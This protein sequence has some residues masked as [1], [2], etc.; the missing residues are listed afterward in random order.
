MRWDS[1]P[2]QVANE[3]S[4]R[5]HGRAHPGSARQGGGTGGRTGGSCPGGTGRPEPISIRRGDPHGHGQPQPA[6]HASQ[7]EHSGS[8]VDTMEGEPGIASSGR[9]NLQP[10][11]HEQSRR[12]AGSGDGERG[13]ALEREHG[14]VLAIQSGRAGCGRGRRARQSGPSEPESGSRAWDEREGAGRGT[15]G[16]PTQPT[17]QFGPPAFG[18]RQRGELSSE[19]SRSVGSE[20]KPDELSRSGRVTGRSSRRAAAGSVSRLGGSDCEQ[21]AGMRRGR[22]V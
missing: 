10:D 12:R 9:G 11:A 2:A 15:G 4:R 17:Q 6:R 14:P 5:E 1:V 19:A 22:K 18:G 16:R 8:A 3:A 7:L 21:W 20:R 13:A